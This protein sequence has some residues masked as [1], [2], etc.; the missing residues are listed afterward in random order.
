MASTKLTTLHED[1]GSFDGAFWQSVPTDQRLE[2]LWD[3]TLE[4]SEWRGDDAGQSRLQRSVCR[5][6][7]R[8]S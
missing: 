2:L 6:Q 1:D 7:R 3:L 4:Y 5:V 8:P